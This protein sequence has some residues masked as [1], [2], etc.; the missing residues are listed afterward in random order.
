MIR[1]EL[2]QY[3]SYRTTYP[4]NETVATTGRLDYLWFR[5]PQYL[6]YE[7]LSNRPSLLGLNDATGHFLARPA[8]YD[9]KKEDKIFVIRESGFGE[10]YWMKFNQIYSGGNALFMLGPETQNE[11]MEQIIKKEKLQLGNFE[12]F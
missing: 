10:E 2:P 12:L 9:K 5:T 8:A 7:T 4:I 3:E 6:Y 1:I 11:V